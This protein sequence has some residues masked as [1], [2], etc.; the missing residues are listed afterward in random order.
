MCFSGDSDNLV[1]A[2]IRIPAYSSERFRYLSDNQV[3]L[4]CTLKNSTQRST[5]SVYSA[6][7]LLSDGLSISNRHT[8]LNQGLLQAL[9]SLLR[10]MSDH[11]YA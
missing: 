6:H 9:E 4:S 11:I 3:T 7:M 8:A 5:R 1:R 10:F 2:K